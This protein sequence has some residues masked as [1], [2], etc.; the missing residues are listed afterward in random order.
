MRPKAALV[1][2]GFTEPTGKK[3]VTGD[4][5]K[6]GRLSLAAHKRLSELKAKGWVIDNGAPVK[7]VKDTPVTKKSRTVKQDVTGVVDHRPEV[8]DP[9]TYRAVTASGVDVG[10]KYVCNACHSSFNFCLCPEPRAWAEYDRE[11]TVYFQPVKG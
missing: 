1:K 4:E 11:E 9:K 2:D 6:R 5:D 7:P 10:A 3:W 8:R